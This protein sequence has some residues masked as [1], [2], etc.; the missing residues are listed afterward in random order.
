MR[1]AVF[2]KRAPQFLASRTVQY[3]ESEIFHKKGVFCLCALPR[4]TLRVRTILSTL[5]S[6]SPPRVFHAESQSIIGRAPCSRDSE[7]KDTQVTY[8]QYAI[9]V[10]WLR[11]CAPPF[12]E[13]SPLTV[14]HTNIWFFFKVFFIVFKA[15]L[16]KKEHKSR[17]VCGPSRPGI[18]TFHLIH[19]AW[20]RTIACF[21]I[22]L[23]KN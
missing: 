3:L 12:P 20:S 16:L 17:Y 8:W 18:K 15:V 2:R 11:A 4:S 14:L 21:F 19:A 9:W 22:K 7:Y 23:S 10:V 5:Q 6:R 1:A 13:S